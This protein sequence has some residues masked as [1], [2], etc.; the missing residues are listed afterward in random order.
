MEYKRLEL[1]DLQLM[2]EFVDDEN[3]KYDVKNLTKFIEG[4]NNYGFIAKDNNKIIAFLYGYSLTHPDGKISF[5]LDAI[6]V[7]PEY[8]NKGIGTKL[9][10]FASSYIK[11]LGCYEIFLVTNK[12]NKAACK[13]YEKAGFKNEA[14]DDIVY[15]YN[16]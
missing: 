15:V 9:M 12:S 13:C 11:E 2:L 6:D 16:L 10:S 7:M 4:K 14:T 5:Y 3:T 1:L 8:Q